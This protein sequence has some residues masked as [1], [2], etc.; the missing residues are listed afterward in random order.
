M[1]HEI[2]TESPAETKKL[3]ANLARKLGAGSVL[4]LHGDLGS[5]KTCFVQG[6]ADALDIREIVNSPTFIIINEYQGCCSLYHIDLYRVK[7]V[8]EAEA[9]GLENILEG[10]GIAAIEWPEKISSLLPKNTIHIY[11]EFTDVNRRRITIRPNPNISSRC[12][13]EGPQPKKK[14][15]K[16]LH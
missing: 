2:I 8:A 3:A 4:A 13:G 11:F 15:E 9:L 1:T 7:S 6:L 10:D 5:G 16:P 12:P 14:R